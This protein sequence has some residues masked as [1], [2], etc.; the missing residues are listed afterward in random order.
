MSAERS[1]GEEGLWGPTLRPVM[2]ALMSVV[3]I[4]SYNNLSVAAA[5]PDVGDDLGYIE[6]LPWV[7]TLELLTSAVAVLA[8]GPVVD[9]LGVRRTFRVTAVGFVATSLLT[10]V[11]PSMYTLLAARAVQGV[12]A[13]A[14]ITVAMAGIGVAV[15]TRLRPRAFASV[16]AVWGVMGV[17]G[18]AMAAGLVSTAGWRGVFAINIPV[19]L[20]ALGVG[21]AVLPDRQAGA[22]R[23]SIDAVGL[24]IMA[25]FAGAV[26][27]LTTGEAGVMVGGLVVLV[28][29]VVAY[30]LWARRVREPIVR[31]P[32][33]LETRYRSVHVASMAVLAGGIGAD[34][35]LPLYVRAVRGGSQAVAAFSVLYLSFGW[36]AAAWVSSRL[37]D[38]WPGERVSLLGALIA[39]PGITLTAVSVSVGA[40]LPVI[41]GA[42]VW[43]GAGV[44]MTTSTGAALLQNRAELTEMGRVNSAHQFLRTIAITIGIALQ[45]AITFA[46]VERRTGD[47]EAVRDLLSDETVAVSKEVLDALAA[48]YTLGLTVLIAVVAT[49]VPA[50]VHLVRTRREQLPSAA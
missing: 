11:A 35:F 4:V 47:V 40:P 13:G 50:A 28:G 16:S 18:P 17:A 23:P 19:T 33:L 24:A 32:H 34:S 27:S 7:I 1:S 8:A 31:I 2:T 37:Q 25:L 14:V 12:F 15:P 41:Y 29:A 43:L 38:R 21:W 39:V 49:S 45:A 22:A 30:G 44:G 6:L 48:G 42:F 26:L 46:V 5:L 36:T 20:A 3:A 10:T 9:G